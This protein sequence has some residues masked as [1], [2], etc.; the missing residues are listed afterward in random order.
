MGTGGSIQSVRDLKAW[1]CGYRLG[2]DVCRLTKSFP[3]D[4]RFGLTSQLRRCGIS[5]AS[6]IAEG[7]GRGSTSEYLRF[8]R[9]ARGSLLELRTQ[10]MFAVDLGY[11]DRSAY[12]SIESASDELG[13][14]LSGLIRSVNESTK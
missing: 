8:L 2:L 3:E 10:M 5:I 11:L 4:E 6:N 1:Q 12:E 9:I 7:Y 14:I 13:R